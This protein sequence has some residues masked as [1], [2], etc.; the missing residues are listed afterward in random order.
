MTPLD[1]LCSEAL[2]ARR[3]VRCSARG[4]LTLGDLPYAER[5][6]A[7]GQ[8]ECLR[9]IEAHIAKHVYPPTVRDLCV[10]LGVTSRVV[11]G[12]LLALRRKGWIDTDRVAA[13]AIRLVRKTV[14]TIVLARAAS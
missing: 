12:H 14:P 1:S 6:L 2:L 5:P 3:A 9:A 10:T 13:R 4:V 11:E 7:P 8:A